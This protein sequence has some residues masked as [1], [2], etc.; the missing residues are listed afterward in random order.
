MRKFLIFLFLALVALRPATATA[1]CG[2]S[3]LITALPADEQE[4]LRN[5]ADAVPNGTG[6]L[7]DA[8]RNGRHVLL[9]GTMHL[10]DPRHEATLDQIRPFLETAD[11]IYLEMGAG[12]EARLQR[13]I[14]A[15]PSLAF[16]TEGPT[17]PD[18]L[19]EEDWDRLRAAMADRGVP[20][21][22]ASQMRP[23]MAMAQLGMT[24][25]DM[26]A[27]QSGKR[28]LDGMI[29]AAAE[30]LD[31]PA[32]ALEPIDTALTAFAAFTQQEQLDLLRYGLSQS[33]DQSADLAVTMAEAYFREE[34]Q[35]IWE[36]TVA[37]S[38]ADET[39]SAEEL[40]DQIARFEKVLIDDRNRAWMDRILSA[41]GDTL[42]A[43]G[44]MHLPGDAGLLHLLEAEGFDV[45]RRARTPD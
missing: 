17:L 36:F 4:R 44:A 13:M 29:T 35:L 43:V 11:T 41:D 31:K 45:T 22:L 20:G 14:A 5:L 38:E 26:E 30:A 1:D 21:F 9:V 8:Q 34:I 19:G 6:I 39:F 32:L 7:W 23:W 16:I 10:Y 2:G 15:E 25:C 40:E 12:D 18:L 28:G 37:L 24:R 42:V 33:T 3:D 27:L